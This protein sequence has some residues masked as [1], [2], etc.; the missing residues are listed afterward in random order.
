MI[1]R[2]ARVAL[3]ANRAESVDIAIA[4]GRIRAL[5]FVPGMRRLDC[6]G[7]LVLPG[8]INAHDHLEFNLFPRLGHGPYESAS[9]WARDIHTTFQQPIERVLAVPLRE[10]LLW[11]G[12]KNLVSGVTSVCHHNPWNKVFSEQ[13]PVRVVRAF[14]WAHS[15]EFSGDLPERHAACPKARPFVFHAGEAANGTGRREME[16]LAK[17]GLFAS[18]SVMVHAV[19]LRHE[20]LSLARAKGCSLVWCPSSNLFALGKTLPRHVL[21][22][23]LPIALGTDSALTAEGDMIDELRVARRVSGLSEDRLYRMVTEIAAQVLRLRHGEGTIQPGAVADLLL[24]RDRGLTPAQT[25]LGQMPEAVVVK[26]VPQL[27]SAELAS[28][29]GRSLPQISGFSALTLS[30]RGSLRLRSRIP[31]MPAGLSLAGKQVTT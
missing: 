12:I 31:P 15:L 16:T 22:S 4:G 30:G 3:S 9:Q 1:L 18:N 25:L 17:L 29:W 26:G 7:Y 8:L 6:G 24:Y 11:G 23:G 14:S 13:F 2:G 21:E 27:V 19:G 5:G 28:L 10:R 20:S